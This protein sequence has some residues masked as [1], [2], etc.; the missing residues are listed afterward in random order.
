MSS[1]NAEKLPKTIHVWDVQG[2]VRL[3]DLARE[4]LK[5][6]IRSYG[7]RKLE[8]KLNFDRETI[9][10]IYTKDRKKDVH[11]IKHLL[12]V[13]VFLDYDLNDLEKEITAYGR[14]QTN[15]Y[16]FKFPFILTPLHI[17]AVSIHGDGS[18]NKL[19]GQCSWYQKHQHI[20]YME[21][22]LQLIFQS[23][24][25]TFYKKDK[26]VSSITIPSA[27]VYLACKS[28]KMQLKEF[29]SIKFFKR[30]CKTPEEFQFQ[31]FSQFIIDE[32]HF[33]GT[34]FTVSQKKQKTREGFLMLLDSLK[35]EHSDPENNKDDVTI[36]GYN[37]SKILTHLNKATEKYGFLAGFWFKEE[38]FREIC[39]NNKEQLSKAVVEN[40][41]LNEEIF[42]KLRKRKLIFSYKDVREYGRTSGEINKAIRCWK[43]NGLVERIDW[44]RYKM[45][46]EYI[47]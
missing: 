11:S 1:K 6:L 43:K 27:L 37:Y 19:N 46:E 5:K 40:R 25:I 18:F 3:S 41:K 38:K 30:I 44:D 7:V 2:F 22:L 13:A 20:T 21:K 9:Y 32:G 35:L 16:N 23:K 39:E 31:V 15:M 12:K 17:R 8:R 14:M 24:I 45:L 26:V 34:T 36:Y 29:S 47:K 10:S 4:E 28:L 33:E 42:K